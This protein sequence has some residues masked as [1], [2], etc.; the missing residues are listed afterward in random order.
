MRRL[1]PIAA[2]SLVLALLPGAS[3]GSHRKTDIVVLDTG[4]TV[5]GEIKQ[6]DRGQL[7]LKTDNMGTIQIEWNH[8]GAL[9]SNYFYRVSDGD[10]E[11]YYGRLSIER[12]SGILVVSVGNQ[13][14]SIP[15]YAVVEIVPIEESF[16]HKFDGSLSFGFTYTKASDVAQLTFDWSN[17]FRTERNLVDS[18]VNTIVTDKGEE[19]TTTRRY[20]VNV[21]YYRLL[22]AQRWNGGTTIGLQRNDELSLARRLTLGLSAGVNLV[23]SNRSH[24]LLG[25]GVTGNSELPTDST[26]TIESWEIALSGS[27]SFF[28]YDSPKTDISTNFDFYPSITE[29]GR[30][31]IEYDLKLRYELLKSFYIDISFYLSYDS[32]PVSGEGEQSDW[33]IVTG[34][35]WSY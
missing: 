31:R 8:I 5:H 2:L 4:D 11:R 16:W 6:L 26:K 15:K 33:G 24:L 7:E 35:S 28:R 29:E 25:L 3:E 12:G 19:G 14:A 21:S 32:Q 17:V 22:A 9:E 10:G 30:Y 1:F 18:K 34:I 27:Y 20:D 13:T 23:R